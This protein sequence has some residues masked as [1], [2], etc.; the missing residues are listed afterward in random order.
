M[1]SSIGIQEPSGEYAL[2]EE[3]M[4][5]AIIQGVRFV[6]KAIIFIFKTITA[7][8]MATIILA[9]ILPPAA[10]AWRTTQPM[11]NPMFNGLSLY[12][13][14][15]LRYGQYQ[16]FVTRYELNHPANAD[17]TPGMCFWDDLKASAVV[18]AL[19][20]VSCAIQTSECFNR[21]SLGTDTARTFPAMVWAIFEGSLVWAFNRGSHHP[22]AACRMPLSFPSMNNTNTSR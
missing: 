9:I 15:K 7:V 11:D 1:R 18:S 22:V 19:A 12:Q 20:T 8:V 3:I 17:I 21:L 2:Q 5:N 13:V 14:M 4:K 10:F 6:L 16:D